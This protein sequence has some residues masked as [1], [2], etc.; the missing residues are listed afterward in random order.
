MFGKVL[1]LVTHFVGTHLTGP[2]EALVGLV[3][4]GAARWRQ[5]LSLEAGASVDLLD[6]QYQEHG[7]TYRMRVEIDRVS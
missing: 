4:N 6:V 7:N 2:E 1:A 3:E 5:Y